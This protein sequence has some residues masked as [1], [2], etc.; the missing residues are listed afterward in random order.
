VGN[1]VRS[2]NLIRESGVIAIVRVD[3]PVELLKIVKAVHRGG[4]KAVE[5]T[6]TTP[7][8]LEAIGEVIR[9][10]VEDILLGVGTVLDGETARMAILAGAEFVVSP[11]VSRGVI[12][13]SRRYGKLVIPGAMTPTEILQAWEMGGDIIKVFPATTLGPQ[14]FRDLKGPLPQ[15]P[16]MPTGGVSIDNAGE[17]IRAGAVAVGVGG[18]LVD[19]K[20]VKEGRFDVLTERAG[21]LVEVVK[22]TRRE[23]GEIKE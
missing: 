14:Y 1:Q 6:M 9:Q 19:R 7:G 18:Q 4:V 3:S 8:A 11:T 22:Q 23:L 17:F 10:G 13:V 2:F 5:I 15:I 21:R 16:L 20:T 12:E